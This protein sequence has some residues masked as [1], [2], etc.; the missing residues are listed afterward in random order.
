MLIV[1]FLLFLT[2]LSHCL[3]HKQWT[4]DKYYEITAW[5]P[6]RCG[7]TDFYDKCNELMDDVTKFINDRSIESWDI[8]INY[9]TSKSTH[10][11]TCGCVITLLYR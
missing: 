10:S 8:K 6:W 1:F 2:G 7:N 5:G 9:S 4:Y 3:S 11:F